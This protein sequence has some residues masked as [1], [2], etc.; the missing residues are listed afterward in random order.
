MEPDFG[1]MTSWWDRRRD[2]MEEPLSGPTRL[3]LAAKKKIWLD[4]L[5]NLHHH[6]RSESDWDERACEWDSSAN[7]V[8]ESETRNE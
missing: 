3:L 2:T 8:R 7:L 5:D 4:F 1:T 6:E